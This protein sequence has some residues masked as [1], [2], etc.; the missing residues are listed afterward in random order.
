MGAR[1]GRDFLRRL[2]STPREV[3]YGDQKITGSVSQHPAFKG[4]AKS[5]A[6]LYDMQFKPGLKEFMTYRSPKSGEPVGTSFL[7][8]RTKEELTQRTRMMRAW[9]EY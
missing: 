4:V 8:P 6:A 7:Q 3:W 5:M 2:D 1:S 9:E